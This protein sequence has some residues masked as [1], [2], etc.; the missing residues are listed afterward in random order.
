MTRTINWTR[1]ALVLYGLAALATLL[2][3][4]GAPYPDAA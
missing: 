2:Y 4:I 1:L 3:T